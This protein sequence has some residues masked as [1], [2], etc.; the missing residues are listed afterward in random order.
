MTEKKPPL[1]TAVAEA[2]ALWQE[3]KPTLVEMIERCDPA[4]KGLSFNDIE[5]HSAATGDLLAK[6]MMVRAVERQP[7]LTV[8]EEQAAR[9]QALH[10]ADLA[11]CRDPSDLLM[12]RAGK[13][14]RKLKTARGEITFQ[15]DYLY[16]PELKAGL[17]PPGDAAGNPGGFT[18]AP[19][20]PGT[21][22]KG[23]GG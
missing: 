18:D 3:L 11:G 13:R 10:K 17:F 4:V 23:G 2:E 6:L 22:G 8:A 1:P 12:T 20:G 19:R 9:A 5:G 14:E 15:R 21:Y 7:E 16:F